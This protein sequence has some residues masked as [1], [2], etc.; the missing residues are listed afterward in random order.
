M[1]RFF[2]S[3]ILMRPSWGTRRSAMSRRDITLR[4]AASFCASCH[5]RLRDSLQHAVHAEAHAVD[6]LVG[7]EM[8][9]RGAAADGI[10]QDLVDEAH[11][12]RVFDI[13]AADLVVELVV[14]AGDSGF[15]VEVRP[16]R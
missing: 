12:W 4:R 13:I 11:D 10:E 3:F 2:D 9:V 16:R 5:R 7:L 15:E 8:D 14:A 6:L 1:A